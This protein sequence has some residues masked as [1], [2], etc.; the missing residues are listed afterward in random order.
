MYL[1]RMQASETPPDPPQD[2][3]YFDTKKGTHVHFPIR[4]CRCNTLT[5][6]NLYQKPQCP[7]FSKNIR[8]TTIRTFSLQPSWI[9]AYEKCIYIDDMLL[10]AEYWII[11]VFFIDTIT[12][13]FSAASSMF[14]RLFWLLLGDGAAAQWQ[15]LPPPQLH[16]PTAQRRHRL[17]S[18]SFDSDSRNIMRAFRCRPPG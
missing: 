2:G 8:F 7:N 10:T 12:I 6:T 4:A 13:Q 9:R 15:Y 18:T 16:S 11:M 3:I 5:R 14:L 17:C 1:A